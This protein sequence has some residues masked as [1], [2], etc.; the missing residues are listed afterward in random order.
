MCMGGGDMGAKD[1]AAH[2]ADLEAGR[3][4]TIALG[5]KKID[6]AF[7][8]FDDNFYSNIAK[9]YTDYANPQ[10]DTQYQQALKNLTYALARS[11]LSSSTAAGTEQANLDK[12]YDQY[13]TDVA[14]EGQSEADRARSNNA[15][16]RNTL[17]DQLISTNDQAGAG[18]QAVSAAGMAS[19]P[20]T[21]SP[22]GNFAFQMAQGLQNQSAQSGYNP[23]L[24]P[25]LFG[26]SS[27]AAPSGGSNVTYH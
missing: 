4:R 3:Q 17:V 2:Q 6:N 24:S 10:L 7:A 9:S 12:Q 8:G 20:P 22:V 14:S 15:N 26:Q 5:T 18:A 13:R 27:L 19:K 1:A 16:T 25:Y 21:F 23:L 11:G